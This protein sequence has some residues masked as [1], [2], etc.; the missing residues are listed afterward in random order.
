MKAIEVNGCCD[1]A[2]GKD[3]LNVFRTHFLHEWCHFVGALRCESVAREFLLYGI[4][5][6]N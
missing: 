1:P 5:S 6:M 3:V 2:L 4:D